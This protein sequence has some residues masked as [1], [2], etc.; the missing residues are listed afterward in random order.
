MIHHQPSTSDPLGPA[1]ARLH[2]D[3]GLA[4]LSKLWA[5]IEMLLGLLV[6]GGGLFL[7]VWAVTRPPE[8]DAVL[9]VAG[10]VLFALGGC[11]ALAGHR[12]HLYQSNNRLAAYLAEQ[13]RQMTTQVQLHEHPR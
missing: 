10:V 6:A 7:G 2:V 3:A 8:V 9:V 4:P 5:R 11:L 12:S 13:I 1:L